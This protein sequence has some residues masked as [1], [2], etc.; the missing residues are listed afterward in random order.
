MNK[1]SEIKKEFQELEKK[2]SDPELMS[3]PKEFSQIAKD[4]A[5]LK[6][7]YDLIISLEKIEENI[8]NNQEIIK[9]E[10]DT[11]LLELA[12]EDLKL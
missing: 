5:T 11:E 1:Y 2:I 6:K 9:N 7:V 3:N 8:T 10:S 12:Q 4:H